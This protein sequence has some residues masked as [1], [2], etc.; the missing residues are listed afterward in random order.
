MINKECPCKKKKC[1]GWGDCEA[2][3]ERHAA[4]NKKIPVYCERNSAISRC[5][6]NS[7]VADLITL[8]RIVGTLVLV[9][10]KPLS[11]AFFC[12]YTLTGITDALD[13]WIARK[14]K[15][16]S[17]FGAKLDSIAD[18]L[19]YAVM[20][21]RIFPTLWSM[22]PKSIWYAVAAVFVIRISAYTAA[23]LRYRLFASMH[24][25][26]NKLTGAAVFLAPFS[27]VT[28]F[29]VG[30]CWAVTVVAATASFEELII[31]ISSKNY[32]ANRK[33]LLSIR[34]RH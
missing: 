30:Y 10:L 12:I 15:T 7:S 34:E 18:M 33:S 17:D 29:A 5:K 13:G 14:T 4:S 31:H 22:L 27:L 25:Y 3:R 11:A 28:D 9:A 21:V 2:C 19:F 32:N 20:L 1:S 23:A 26:L 16:A 24:T 6:H 8:I